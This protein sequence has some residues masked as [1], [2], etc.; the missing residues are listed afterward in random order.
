M[1]ANLGKNTA[2]YAGMGLKRKW[3]MIAGSKLPLYNTDWSS[4]PKI[5]I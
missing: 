3:S 1:G 5:L 2:F 4:L